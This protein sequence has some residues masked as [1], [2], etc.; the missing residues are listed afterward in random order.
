MSLMQLPSELS[1]GCLKVGHPRSL[2][3][4]LLLMLAPA[5]RSA[6]LPVASPA[7]V[8][9]AFGLPIWRLAFYRV[10][11]PNEPQRS[12]R[13]LSDLAS[14]VGIALLLHSTGYKPVTKGDPV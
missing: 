8:L 5:C 13:T 2:L 3:T 7:Q 1:W 4:C 12:C 11:N 6:S 14:D 9:R 10:D